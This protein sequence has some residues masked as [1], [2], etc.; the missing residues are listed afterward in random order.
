MTTIHK[1]L[2]AAVLAALAALIA[3]LFLLWKKK[4]FTTWRE[5]PKVPPE[6][7]EIDSAIRDAEAQLAAAHVAAGSRVANLPV[8]LLMGDAG[9]AKTS[10]MLQS[11]IEPE[12]IA[13]QVFENGEIAAT[14]AVNI[15][16][17]SQSLF[18]EAG[19][20]LPAD[21]GMWNRLL[22]K[23]APRVS[24]AGKS[25]HPP[26]AALVF[27]N[28]EQFMRPEAQAGARDA[29]RTIRARLGEMAQAMGTDLPVYVL[30][31]KTDRIPYFTEYVST[32]SEEEARQSFGAALPRIESRGEAGYAETQA[33]RL[34]NH[35][36]RLFCSLADARPKFL[37]RES[38]SSRLP[39]TYEFPREFRKIR[40]AAVQFLVEL[41]RP[42]QLKAGPFLRGFYFTGIRP[43]AVSEDGPVRAVPVAANAEVAPGATQILQRQALVAGFQAT[44]PTLAL[45]QGPAI[46]QWVF[47]G[48][49]FNDVLL[50]DRSGWA[51]G[52]PN[53]KAG[54]RRR[55]LLAAGATAFTL[56]A[57]LFTVSFSLNYSLTSGIV[58]AAAPPGSPAP[59]LDTAAGLSKLESLRQAL[60]QLVS[61]RKEGPPLRYRFGLYSGEELY[62]AARRLYYSRFYQVLLDRTQKAMAES[63]R[64]L[65]VTSGPE[66]GPT[67]DALKAYLITTANHEK[68]T[69]AFLTPELLKWWTLA[70]GADP[71]RQALARAQFDF[72]ADELRD[73]NPFSPENDAATVDK[74]RRYLRQF[75]GLD[76]IYAFM[77]ADA[78]KHGSPVNF[79]RLFPGSA[80]VVTETHEV[81]AAF[82]KT[83][84]QFMSDA[85]PHAE[86][87]VSGETWVLGD[88]AAG[89]T[90]PARLEQDLRNR[91]HA[92]FLHEWR[93][94]LKSAAVTPYS[95]IKDATVKLGTISGNQS[96]LLALFAVASRNTAV[97]DPAV[98][99]V[100]QPVQ[101]MV[102]PGSEDRYIGQ[103]NQNYVNAL[104]TLQ[105]S[106]ENLTGQGDDPGAA[107]ALNNAQ[108]ATIVSRQMAQSFRLDND[109]H[110]EASVEK[111]MED[112]ITGVQQAL[113]G[114]A[115][116][117]M[118]AGGKD[119]CAKFH[120]VT[121]KFP[122]HPNSKTDATAAEMDMLLR[123]PDGALWTFYEKSLRKALVKQDKQFVPSGATALNPAFV[124]FFN[125]A[126]AISD[127]LYP[128]G[129]TEP[130]LTYTV[131][132]GASDGVQGITLRI[133]NQ[134]LSYIA[135]EPP[136][137][138]SFTWQ[139]SA[140][141]DVTVN[142]RVGGADFE[143]LHYVGLWGAFHFFADAKHTP[144]G[145]EWA[146]GAGGQQFKAG[147]RP[148]TVRLEVELG[149]LA[150][151]LQTG[152]ACVAEVA[153]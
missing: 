98:A 90:D 131:K 76:R 52:A 4:G 21:P 128:P 120:A 67:Y 1:W 107:Q 118:N 64:R 37:S 85:L 137:A 36:D 138:K 96:P 62:P 94:Y 33:A 44:A 108:Q 114:A 142:V 124:S 119:L 149:S 115:P 97:D 68:S 49:L 35:F 63:F 25:G 32:F 38:D 151:V 88:Q 53:L 12:L 65:P 57:I 143:W 109:G 92:D 84:W 22:R 30:F 19:S 28:C 43:V 6:T 110:I 129:A 26:R 15:W 71:A 95:D 148:V 70:A 147:G 11:G 74:A 14:R 139:A 111:L 127:A 40:P 10:F 41:C 59:S 51:A 146:V 46:P 42:S 87:Y 116:S 72:Y 60:V 99:S 103:T 73:A 100:F 132:P 123:R 13:G 141:H 105:A 31:T 18:V 134:T 81:P 9:A 117:A 58:Q 54:R 23:L 16:F 126:A 8:F 7:E 55:V 27:F 106:L 47:L 93:L 104:V 136:M 5:K 153:R 17:H 91:Y 82:S 89:V 122:F 133:D 86:R 125:K 152:M 121:A 140:P 50:S 34:T 101:A 45:A 135:G 102:P 83:A 113:R 66:Y 48:R 24:F 3:W 2:I 39:A 79:N 78:A 112:P 69:R 145:L 56:A 80:S 144:Q 75:A 77:L 29:A 61:F 130:N 20:K 150:T